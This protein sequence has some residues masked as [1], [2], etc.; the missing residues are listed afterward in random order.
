MKKKSAFCKPLVTHMYTADPAVKVY[1]GK[2]YIYPSHDLG[3]DNP[4]DGSGDHFWM[5]D[6]HVFSMDDIDAPCV[7]HGQ[8]IHLDDVPWAHGQMWD[9]DVATKNGKYYMYFP[10][11]D[12]D[13]IFRI[14]VAISDTPEGPFIP[15][16]KPMEGA[17]SIDPHV[18]IDD[19]G[20][21]YMY[22]GGL[23]GG[24][25]EKWQTGEYVQGPPFTQPGVDGPQGDEPAL[26]PYMVELNDDMISMKG[27]PH[28][29]KILDE[30]GELLKAS[31]TERRFFEASW[32]HKF[33]DKYYFSYSTGD[34][35][36]LCYAEGDNPFG[37]FT[38][39]GVLLEP[40]IGWTNHHSVVQFKGK[41]YLFYHDSTISGGHTQLRGIKF[42]EMDIAE[43]GTITTMVPYQT[44]EEILSAASL[45]LEKSDLE[46]VTTVFNL[47]EKLQ[48]KL[49]VK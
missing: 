14:G 4:D 44:E 25:M 3:N 10:A 47:D 2:L 24:Q 29:I 49:K 40:V 11:K 45:M 1:N 23:W 13:G 26:L 27:E 16:A 41:W 34:T 37:P 38:Y 6:Y 42:T 30:N 20:K 15:E 9:N 39:K 22:Y 33:N 19:D 48:E 32:L 43:D 46:T 31:D 35:H 36:N 12:K 5:E 28:R 21:A 18:F 17:Y 8:A 7:D